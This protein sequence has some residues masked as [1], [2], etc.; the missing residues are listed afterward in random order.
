MDLDEV[1]RR[2]EALAA[3]L[4]VP[5]PDVESGNLPEWCL[6]GLRLRRKNRHVVVVVGNAFEGLSAVE[7]EGAL[8]YMVAA[9]GGYAGAPANRDSAGWKRISQI[10]G[11]VL[12]VAVP[13]TIFFTA[14]GSSAALGSAVVMVLSMFALL[15]VV[16]SWTRRM[17]YRTDHLVTEV[18]GRPVMEMLLARER[19]GPRPPLLRSLYVRAA[20]PSYRRRVERL[21]VANVPEPR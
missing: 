13:L 7:Q 14:V 21:N 15:A 11:F 6:S 1:G 18:M 17:I 3:R 12:G 4:G 20:V 19:G 2:S 16:V 10:V 5:A 8:A 9:S